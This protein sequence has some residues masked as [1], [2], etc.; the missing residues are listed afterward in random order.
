MVLSARKTRRP[1]PRP[2][3]SV[4]PGARNF[5]GASMNEIATTMPN[6]VNA[7]A[8]A[9]APPPVMR[10]TELEPTDRWRV[11]PGSALRA[12]VCRPSRIR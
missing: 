10:P 7:V 6:H 1:M 2:M 3:V 8:T 11:S 4:T 12:R 9:T 5:S